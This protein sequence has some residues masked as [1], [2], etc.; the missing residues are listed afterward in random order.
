MKSAIVAVFAI[1]LGC[2]FGYGLTVYLH[3]KASGF[4]V[5]APLSAAEVDPWLEPSSGDVH[6]RLV[7][8]EMAFDAGLVV[9][10]ETIS[11]NFRITNSGQAPLHLKADGIAQRRYEFKLAKN[12]LSPGES[13]TLRFSWEPPETTGPVPMTGPFSRMITLSSN[14]PKAKRTLLSVSAMRVPGPSV[15]S[16]KIDLKSN[17]SDVQQS[18][19]TQIYAYHTD[20][21][22]M[23]AP[24]FTEPETSRFFEVVLSPLSAE[25]LAL[26][27]ESGLTPKAGYDVSITVKPGLPMGKVSQEISFPMLAP[28]SPLSVTVVGNIKSDVSMGGSAWNRQLQAMAFGRVFARDG[29]EREMI[30]YFTGEHRNSINLQ[31]ESANPGFLEVEVG[32]PTSSSDG[33]AVSYKITVQVPV[34]A[35]PV[36]FTGPIA[37]GEFGMLK[38]TTDH[39][40][41]KT[42]QV[43]VSMTV[44]Q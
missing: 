2:G 9:L 32:S 10:S 23:P 28:L 29:S 17:D 4:D 33:Q 12:D 39:P 3:G 16:D 43:P 14:D 38:F 37:N 22:T 1:A 31:F 34:N 24:I 19:S 36:E 7:I 15:A 20:K 21:L 13:T 35:P 8:D 25:E 30:L 11:H 18:L 26:R 27:P 42:L 44:Y 5:L 6:P 40:Q 41:L